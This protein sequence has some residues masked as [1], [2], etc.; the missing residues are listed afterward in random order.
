MGIEIERK[1]LVEGDQWKSLA[2]GTYYRQGYVVRDP[3]T[4]VRV[5]IAGTLGFLTLKG[6]VDH[7]ARPEFEYQIPLDEAQQMMDLW[8]GHQVIEK[9]RYCIS[10]QDMLWEVDEF[11]GENAGLI[12]AEVELQSVDQVFESPAWVGE[13]V[14][15][16]IRYYNSYLVKHPYRTWHNP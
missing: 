2:T 15:E 16:D 14:S 10:Y 7:L 3:A 1:F 12:I 11:L 13:E 8:C 9:N 4:T 6:R 5:R